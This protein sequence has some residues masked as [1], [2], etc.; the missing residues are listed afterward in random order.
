MNDI[1]NLNS[2]EN[3]EKYIDHTLLKADATKEMIKKLCEEAVQYGFY[4]VCVNSCHVNLCKKLVA[5]S[6]VKIC[7][8]IGFPLGAADSDSKVFEAKH[9]VENGADE[10]DMVINVGALKSKDYE[11]VFNDIKQ[12][13]KAIYDTNKNAILKVIIETCLLTDEEKIKACELSLD[14]KAHFVK[15]STG[16]STGG[17]TVSDIKLMKNAAKGKLKVKASGGIR[18][19]N[20]AIQMINAGADRIGASAS[21]KIFKENIK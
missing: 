10:I 2:I 21:V 17:A 6:D 20:D 5:N 13:V 8:V 12:V 14:A 19:L 11:Y 9:A 18:T 4:S 3:I 7:S 16:F 15:T 1:N